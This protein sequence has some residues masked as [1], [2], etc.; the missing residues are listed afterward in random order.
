MVALRSGRVGIGGGGINIASALL[1][2]VPKLQQLGAECAT[3]GRLVAGGM[4]GGGI[5]HGEVGV[6]ARSG[7]GSMT[8]G[9]V[10]SARYDD[11]CAAGDV[12]ACD[13]ITVC[14]LLEHICSLLWT[15]FAIF[16][17]CT[18]FVRIMRT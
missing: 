5:G 3:V 18:A 7:G 17:F 9:D 16:I 14:G 2:A 8:N 1:G 6:G 13:T 11:V 10:V 12:E 15:L 4:C